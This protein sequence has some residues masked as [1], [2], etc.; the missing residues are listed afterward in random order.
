MYFYSD[1]SR[2]GHGLAEVNINTGQTEREA[3]LSDLDERFVTDEALRLM[4]VGSGNRMLAY[5]VT[6]P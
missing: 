4:F 5:S 2:A 3:R 1:L 6:A